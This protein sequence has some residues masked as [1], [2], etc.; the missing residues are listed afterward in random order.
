M[1][2]IIPRCSPTFPS[3]S[4]SS[5]SSPRPTPRRIMR[6]SS[7]NTAIRKPDLFMCSFTG[8]DVAFGRKKSLHRHLRA[9]L[10]TN[11]KQCPHCEARFTE[12]ANLKAHVNRKHLGVRHKCP[13]CQNDFSDRPSLIRHRKRKH[14]YQSRAY[15]TAKDIIKE[16]EETRPGQLVI[17]RVS[18]LPATGFAA[19]AS[20]L[21]L[22]P[23]PAP[24]PAP[25]LFLS[26]SPSPSPPPATPPSY[27]DANNFWDWYANMGMPELPQATEIYPAHNAGFPLEELFPAT[28][29]ATSAFFSLPESFQSIPET[30]GACDMQASANTF[31]D[32]SAIA[33]PDLIDICADLFGCP[34]F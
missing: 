28:T 2:S 14:N 33:D 10:K 27:N 7:N 5:Q 1:I 26:P 29:M 3:E 16:V 32:Y 30:S 24:A 15:R 31:A 34:Q 17:Q 18:I 9:H 8:C 23:A 21:F 11:E 6:V 4:L 25:A 20:T 19:A 13:D 12:T 22:S